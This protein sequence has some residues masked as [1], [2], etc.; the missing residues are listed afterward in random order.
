M[1]SPVKYLTESDYA[2]LPIRERALH[3]ARSL[4]FVRE[5]KSNDGYWVRLF[6]KLAGVGIPAPWCAAFVWYCLKK[7]GFEGKGP[8]F[9]AS[10]YYWFVWARDSRRL[11]QPIHK[12]DAKARVMR[13]DL[14]IWNGKNG[15]H[16]GFVLR[17][18]PNG[19]FQT[20]EGNTNTAGARE[21]IGVFERVRTLNELTR[22]KRWGLI[23]ID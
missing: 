23:R 22:H 14:F 11:I 21:G 7:A 6:L 16:I 13:G 9:P 2:A 12:N 3:V 15:G 4:D 5:T 8:K 19:D 1:K 10:T 20:L 17:V 18:L